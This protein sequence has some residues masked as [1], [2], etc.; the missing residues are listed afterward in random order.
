MQNDNMK[1]TYCLFYN[2]YSQHHLNKTKSKKF[3]ISVFNSTFPI[4]NEITGKF[5]YK[6][7]CLSV[8]EAQ[9]LIL[10]LGIRT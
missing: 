8:L 9:N 5:L 2:K 7:S 3:Q 6:D 10:S 1:S 4:S